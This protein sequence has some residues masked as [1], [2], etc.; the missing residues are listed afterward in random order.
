MTDGI[1]RQFYRFGL[2]GIAGFVVDVA[3]LYAALTLLGSGP[4]IG[5]GMSYLAA[6]SSTWYLNRRVTFADRR[7]AAIGGE[8]LRFV[9]FNAAGGILNYSTYAA[10]LHYMGSSGLAPAT[11]VALGSLVGLCLNFGLSRQLVFR[12]PNSPASDTSG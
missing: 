12:K 8:W 5:R 2:V 10:Y 9:L 3:V 6:A 7:S 4:Y 1:L 11:G